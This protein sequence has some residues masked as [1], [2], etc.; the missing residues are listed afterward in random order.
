MK[1]TGER[2]A[3]AA[4]PPGKRQ[5]VHCTGVGWAL[6][7]V[8]MGV[9]KLVPAGV[10][11]PNRRPVASCCTD[12]GCPVLPSVYVDLIFFPPLLLR[13]KYFPS[14][15]LLIATD[16]T[17]ISDHDKRLPLVD[18]A[19][20]WERCNCTNV[21]HLSVSHRHEPKSRVVSLDIFRYHDEFCGVL[22]WQNFAESLMRL[23]SCFRRGVYANMHL[24]QHTVIGALE[25]LLVHCL[26]DLTLYCKHVDRK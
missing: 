18:V 20:S 19:T 22:M 10:R 23:R 7:P 9:V 12:N 3:Q 1:A 25:H 24:V 17:F 2:H 6:G 8:W 21:R 14:R 5:G 15:K 16:L 11:S 13:K 26:G 4:L